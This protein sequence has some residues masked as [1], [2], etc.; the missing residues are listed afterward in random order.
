MGLLAAWLASTGGAPA[1]PYSGEAG[2]MHYGTNAFAGWI[3]GY[4]DVQRPVAGSGGYAR[5]NSGLPTNVLTAIAGRPAGFAGEQTCHVLSLGDGGSIILTF[6]AAIHDGP[7][8]DFAVFE[9][10]FTDNSDW[11]G[12][13]RETAGNTFAFAELAFVD[14]GT[15]TSAWAR[16]PVTYLGTGPV[17]NLDN[18]AEDRFASQDVS[19]IDGLAG[20]HDIEHG[21]PFDLADL[22]SDPAVTNGSVDLSNINYIRLTD[23]VGDGSTTDSFGRA[24]HDPYYDYQAGYPAAPPASSTDG[25]DLRAVGVIHFATISTC[26][27]ANGPEI[28]WYATTNIMYQA[29][30]SDDFRG[31]NWHDLGDPVAGACAECVATDAYGTASARFYRVVR[32][33]ESAP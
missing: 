33:R 16:F 7:G 5:D 4:L 10:G 17:H 12:T 24:I 27:G 13:S 1:G 9:N 2:G 20:K 26:A 28:S 14:V 8:P 29:Q 30:W 3:T 31:T 6:A 18:L 25:F 11:T 15:T 21:T 32:W 19:L 22:F 23:V